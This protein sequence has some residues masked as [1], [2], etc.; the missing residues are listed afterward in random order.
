MIKTQKVR[1]A[2]A[3]KQTLLNCEFNSIAVN[4]ENTISLLVADRDIEKMPI[5]KQRLQEQIIARVR[6]SKT[7]V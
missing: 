1:Y 4:W 3:K 5:A 7:L 2:I 6:Y